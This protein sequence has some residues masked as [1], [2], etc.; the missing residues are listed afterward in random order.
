MP[1]SLNRSGG[2]PSSRNR[3][4]ETPPPPAGTLARNANP[5]LDSEAATVG[6]MKDLLPSPRI[7]RFAPLGWERQPGKREKG[8]T[9]VNLQNH[10]ADLLAILLE[11]PGEV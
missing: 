7:F 9:T 8:G 6:A 2:S 1:G 3:P 4:S 10:P 5:L 11:R